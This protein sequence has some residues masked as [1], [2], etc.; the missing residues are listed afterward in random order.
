MTDQLTIHSFKLFQEVELDR[1]NGKPSRAGINC[2]AGRSETTSQA[3][4]AR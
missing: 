3:D 2:R 1:A 4:P